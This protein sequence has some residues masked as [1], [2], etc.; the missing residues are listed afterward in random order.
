MKNSKHEILNSK[1]IQ[2]R[3]GKFET[4][5]GETKN[6]M[7]GFPVKFSAENFLSLFRISIFGFRI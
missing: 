4:I 2:N 7:T 3:V 5:L 1:Q 6:V